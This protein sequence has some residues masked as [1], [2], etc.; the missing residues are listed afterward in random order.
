MWLSLIPLSVTL[1]NSITGGCGGPVSTVGCD[2]GNSSAV[3]MKIPLSP[4]S[5]KG[6]SG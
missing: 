6:L 2:S 3:H 1:A 5:G 4:V